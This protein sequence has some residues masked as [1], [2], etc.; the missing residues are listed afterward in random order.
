MSLNLNT[1]RNGSSQFNALLSETPKPHAAHTLPLSC[2]LSLGR[3]R[4]GEGTI[5]KDHGLR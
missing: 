1:F 5:G 2:P 3:E 4:R